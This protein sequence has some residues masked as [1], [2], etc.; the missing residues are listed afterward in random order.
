MKV[1]GQ[2]VHPDHFVS[3]TANQSSAWVGKGEVGVVPRM[4]AFKVGIHGQTAPVVKLGG[5]FVSG[6]FGQRSQ[7]VA[8][9]VRQ[10]AFVIVGQFKG[11]SLRGGVAFIETK[12]FGMQQFESRGGHWRER[13]F[14]GVGEVRLQSAPGTVAQ[15]RERVVPQYALSFVFGELLGL[16]HRFTR[17]GFTEREGCIRSRAH[18]VGSDAG[19]QAPKG[20]IIMHAGV[21]PKPTHKRTR[22]RLTFG[23]HQVWSHAE[24]MID[25]TQ[26][27]GERSTAVGKAHSEIRM[28]LED[29]AQHHGSH[30][31][32]GFTGH[33]HQP[34]QPVTAHPVR[35]DHV[36]RVNQDGEIKCNTRFPE[37]I[38]LDVIQFSTARLGAD[39]NANKADLG[40]AAELLNGDLWFLQGHGAEGQKMIGVAILHFRKVIIQELVK[41]QRFR[42][43]SKVGKKNRDGRDHLDIDTVSIIERSTT[44]GATAFGLNRSKHVFVLSHGHSTISVGVQRNP[45]GAPRQR[46]HVRKF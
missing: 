3:V 11:V 20:V 22:Q 26:D 16:H 42:G 30:R 44:V 46:F 32:G 25:S 23:G 39:L 4:A 10:R 9:E 18:S 15:E 36:P 12:R 6:L 31:E 1:D 40:N 13:C 37:R 45:T 21:D 33:A 7:T 29:A 2:S 34:L 43:W 35:A 24:A 27:E 14:S 17:N 38:K 41:V 19:D 8:G 28:L 5:Q